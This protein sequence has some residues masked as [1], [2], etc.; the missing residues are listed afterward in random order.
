MGATA[1]VNGLIVPPPGSA[2]GEPRLTTL[3]FD[4]RRVL[5][6]DQPP[7][8]GDTVIDLTGCAVYPGLVNAHDHLELNH[9]PRSKFRDIYANAAQWSADFTPRLQDEPFRTLRQL[10]L[11]EQCRI[12]GEKNRR[13]GV[14]LVAHHNPLHPPLRDPDFPVRVLQRYG[15][16]HSFALERDLM[17]AYRRTPHGAPW[18]IHLA[19][20]T[21]SAAAGE[22]ARLDTLGLLRPNTV[23]IHGVG[24]S[25]A[26]RRRTIAA[27]AGLVWCPSSNLFLLGV[28]ADV[29]EFAQVHRLAL[30]SDSHLTADGDLLDE[31]RAAHATGQL[32]PA[33][34]FR[35]VTL[36]AAALLHMPGA[37]D[38]AIGSFPDFMVI[39]A[40]PADPIHALVGFHS[41]DLASVWIRGSRSEF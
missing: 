31:L 8:R 9:Y 20:G 22:L 1:F 30:G 37:G 18:F 40:V 6:L 4:R 14:T 19:E 35:A 29:R 36:D 17:A 10:P 11:A 5:S 2:A 3:R 15:W 33:Q 26:D 28:T 16:A 32:T 41:S 23:L 24:M 27:G 7:L 12:G 21:D 39:R 13:S 25:E 34:L 38:V